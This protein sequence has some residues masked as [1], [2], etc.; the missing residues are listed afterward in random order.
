MHFAVC[1]VHLMSFSIRPVP[2]YTHVVVIVTIGMFGFCISAT[3]AHTSGVSHLQS[4][5]CSSGYFALL[6]RLGGVTHLV[7]H[8]CFSLF[9]QVAYRSALC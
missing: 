7:E 2:S 8:S 6:D 3:S 9:V 5:T 4:E 1:T